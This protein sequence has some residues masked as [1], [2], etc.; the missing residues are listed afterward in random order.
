MHANRQP[1]DQGMPY[2]SLRKAPRDF[3]RFEQHGRR[4]RVG[5]GFKT[6][7]HGLPTRPHNAE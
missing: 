5:K 3:G 4:D 2:A 1:T 7:G 6:P